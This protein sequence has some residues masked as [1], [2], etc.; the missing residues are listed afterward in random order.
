MSDR[1]RILAFVAYIP[2]IGWIYIWYANRNAGFALFHLRQSVGLILFLLAVFG[3]WI[4]IGWALAWVPYMA[5]LSIALFALVIASW[6]FGIIAWLLGV[7]NAFN[8]KVAYLPVM[9][10]IFNRLP[11]R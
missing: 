10:E 7:A 1:E 4:A 2:V 3:S 6:I 5:V 8:G 11:I 9:G